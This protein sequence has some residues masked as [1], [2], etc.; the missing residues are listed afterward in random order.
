MRALLLI[1]LLSTSALGDASLLPRFSLGL[2]TPAAISLTRARTQGGVGAGLHAAFALDE[3]WLIDAHAAWLWGLGSHSL[4]KLGG[5]WQRSGTW[6]P[7]FRAS[8][9]L[10][11]GGALDFAELGS[12]PSRAPTLG[13]VAGVSLLRFQ[14]GRA[15]VSGLELEGGLSTEFLTV[16]PRFGVTVLS[17]SAPLGE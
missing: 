16:G 6:R 5:G 11:L 7:L 15:F 12:L 3:H 4:F 9:V 8:V 2:E 17:I 13:L 1:P 14:V 10:G